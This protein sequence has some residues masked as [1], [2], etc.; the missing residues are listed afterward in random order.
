M[1]PDELAMIRQRELALQRQQQRERE[2]RH[3]QEQLYGGS[4]FFDSRG[5]FVANDLVPGLRPPIQRQER[6]L[7]N[8]DGI[9]DRLNF[10]AHGRVPGVPGGYEQMMRNMSV[11]QPARGGGNIGGANVYSGISGGQAMSGP[12][13]AEILQA[14]QR[15]QQ[16][17]E[18]ER[19]RQLAQRQQEMERAQLLVMQGQ[20]GP[21]SSRSAS[22]NHSGH[23]GPRQNNLEQFNRSGRLGVS[24]LQGQQLGG[25]GNGG[26][27]GPGGPNV[28]GLSNIGLNNSFG[29]GGQ[30]N[31]FEVP[32]RQQQMGVQ[33]QRQVPSMGFNGEPRYGQQNQLHSAGTGL[34]NQGG[35]QSNDLMALLLAGNRGGQQS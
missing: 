11:N 30:L 6:D 20:G 19:Q 15:E 28:G 31:N 10:A 29:M 34:L 2:Q 14:Q 3:L 4:D 35:G 26:L 18:R 16:I 25:Y 27:N 32:L 22:S 24:D 12:L 5:S 9:D 7:Y 1:Y 23:L 21:L 17:R 33:Q 13:T 8:S